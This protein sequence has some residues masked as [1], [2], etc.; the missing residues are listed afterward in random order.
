M[1]GK[2]FKFYN[3]DLQLTGFARLKKHTASLFFLKYLF[4]WMHTLRK[5]LKEIKDYKFHSSP[6]SHFMAN[7]TDRRKII[8]TVLTYLTSNYIYNRTLVAEIRPI[9][10]SNTIVSQALVLLFIFKVLIQTTTYIPSASLCH[11]LSSLT[12]RTYSTS[13][14][15]SG[16]GHFYQRRQEQYTLQ[17]FSVLWHKDRNTNM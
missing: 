5:I 1:Q 9:K 11:A 13:S 6:A 3:S 14:P 15:L 8:F 7:S 4:N 10:E 2:T 17:V 16:R 12:Q